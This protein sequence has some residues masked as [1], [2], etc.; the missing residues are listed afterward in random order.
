MSAEIANLFRHLSSGVYVIGVADG[1]HRNAFTASSVM[2]VSFS[3]LLVA[4]TV[5]PTHASYALLERSRVFTINVLGE[6]QQALAA[7]FGTQ[8]ARTVD[9]LAAQRWRAGKTGAPL[10]LDA[11]ACFECGVVDDYE[12]GD[13]RLVVAC[14]LDGAVLNPHGSPLLY[15]QTGNLD[16]SEALFPDTFS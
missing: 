14:V 6:H 15:A 10:L 4:L 16:M 7:H 8:S 2:Q 1:E 11:L 9:K 12:A 3:P 13:H 5:G